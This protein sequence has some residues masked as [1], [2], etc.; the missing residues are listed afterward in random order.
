MP[1]TSSPVKPPRQSEPWEVLEGDSV[2]EV[3]M[4]IDGDEDT[5]GDGTV[6]KGTWKSAEN[7]RSQAEG[8]A[9]EFG[10]RSNSELFRTFFCEATFLRVVTDK[11]V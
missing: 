11:Q 5:E 9:G 6:K 4:Q 10:T 2:E 8:S 1:A 7:G 3:A